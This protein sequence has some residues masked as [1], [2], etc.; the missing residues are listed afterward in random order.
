MLTRLLNRAADAA[1][2]RLG[3][4]PRDELRSV[5]TID[6]L[7]LLI[8]S[9]GQEGT[10][11]HD[12]FEMLTRTIRFGHKTAADVLVSRVD[13]VVIG[14]EASVADLVALALDSGY[15]RF[16]IVGDDLDDVI[17]VVHAK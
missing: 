14:R 12:S 8:A 9:S 7:E 11:D 1:V 10:L 15:S 5:R 6:E 3:V 16:P 2:R 13:M 17:G 4:E